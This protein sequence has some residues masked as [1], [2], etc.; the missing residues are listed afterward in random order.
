M[1]KGDLTYPI[2]IF[3][4]DIRSKKSIKKGTLPFINY[5]PDQ[6]IEKLK[7]HNFD[8]IEDGGTSGRRYYGTAVI[9]INDFGGYEW[10]PKF[11]N[12]N[13]IGLESCLKPFNVPEFC[14][15]L[16]DMP[17]VD[18]P[19][20]VNPNSLDP[21]NR[22]FFIQ[23]TTI[24]PNDPCTFYAT[25]YI[26]H[27]QDRWGNEAYYQGLLTSCD[28]FIPKRIYWNLHW[29]DEWTYAGE[30]VWVLERFN[31]TTSKVDSGEFTV[32]Y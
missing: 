6:I 3:P 23:A 8:I 17:P 29:G 9:D 12:S 16:D 1:I 11:G 13:S 10:I 2:N 30:H 31:C 20:A 15:T 18:A 14:Y 19:T 25:H 21:E 7:M 4:I 28:D 27:I 26:L 5:H 22:L 32:I 24:D